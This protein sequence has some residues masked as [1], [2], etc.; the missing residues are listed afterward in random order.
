VQAHTELSSV[1]G[2]IISV[3][4]EVG[5]LRPALFITLAFLT[6][7]YLSAGEPSVLSFEESVKDLGGAPRGTKLV[8][9][10][11]FTNTTQQ[12]V[13]ISGVRT[14]CHCA[15]ARAMKDEIPAGESSSV[16][17]EIN[18]HLYSGSR[19]FTIYVNLDRP[20]VTETRL[21]LKTVSRDDISMSPDAINFGTIKLGAAPS[22]SVVIDHRSFSGWKITGVEN[23]NGYIQTKIEPTGNGANSYRLVV[24]LREDTPAGYW[25][26]SLGLVTNDPT[27]P[28]IRVPLSVEVQ[29]LLAV[30]PQT[31]NMGRLASDTV[32]KKIVIRGAK[33]F[34][35]TGVEGL[36]AILSVDQTKS[37]E[38]KLAHVLKITYSGKADA[39][40]M[41]K[42]LKILTDLDNTSV[43]IPVQGQVVK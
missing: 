36:D 42:K 17:V 8:H 22:A 30:T 41:L 20:Y 21:M 9:H 35:I 12:P 25:H 23:E 14:S 13:H 28:R 29:G 31:L 4:S 7:S 18:T 33:P 16:M 40:E 19:D 34:K 1:G 3:P 43:E 15:T 38:A 2:E 10:F 24:R 27:T 26:A 39:G 32:E 5:M 37:E 11:K 6:Q